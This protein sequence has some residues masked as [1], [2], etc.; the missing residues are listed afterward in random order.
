[1]R[2]CECREMDA[3]ECG[4]IHLIDNAKV[5]TSQQW[6]R[7]RAVAQFLNFR[8]FSR[9]RHSFQD[10]SMQR[11]MTGVMFT[12][13][14]CQELDLWRR[15]CPSQTARPRFDRIS[16]P[17]LRTVPSRPSPVQSI[18]PTQENKPCPDTGRL[19]PTS[20][21]RGRKRDPTRCTTCGTFQCHG[22]RRFRE[23]LPT[24]TLK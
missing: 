13:L 1:M 6:A 9:T 5:K 11:N 15:I 22:T 12:F 19:E 2:V 23:T 20:T 8:S 17:S 14:N 4:V 16:D 3:G 18:G 21:L 24:S 7:D 10:R